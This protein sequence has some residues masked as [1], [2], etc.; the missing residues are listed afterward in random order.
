M[1]LNALRTIGQSKRRRKLGE[2]VAERIISEI[3][4]QGWREGDVLGTERD[5][6][7]RYRVSRATFREAMRQVEWHGAACMRRG[8]HGGVV[9]QAPPREAI[10]FA[11]KTYLELTKISRADRDEVADI[12]R[13]AHRAKPLSGENEAIALFIEAL[14]ERNLEILAEQRRASGAAPKLSEQIAHRIVRDIEAQDA[15]PGTSLGNEGDLQARYGVSR[16]VLR[17]T[18]RLLELHEIVRVKTGSLGGIIVH[19][20]DPGY[21]IELATTYLRYARI[22][23]SH[24]WEAHAALEIAA[25]EKFTERATPEDLARLESAFVRLNTAQAAHYLVAAGEF[26]Q[27]IADGCGNRALAL[28]VRLMLIYVPKV[29]PRPDPRFLPM[30][31]AAHR[32][33]IEAVTAHDV[34]EARHLMNGMFDHSRRWILRNERQSPSGDALSLG[35]AG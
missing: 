21:T 4:Q 32:D 15:A 33:V 31:K 12:L 27:V 28:F 17:E 26:H 25:T 34:E 3:I 19:D 29:L 18:L 9:V 11:F 30:L 35:G 24:L 2:L 13:R 7:D 8:A 1:G 20:V 5:F 14:D 22:P 6:L 16:A 23:M 10:L